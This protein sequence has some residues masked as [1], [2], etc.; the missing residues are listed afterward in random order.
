M[1]IVYPKCTN[2]A[3]NV[4]I[5]LIT[6]QHKTKSNLIRYL[7]HFSC[8]CYYISIKGTSHF[9]KGCSKSCHT[10]RPTV[11]HTSQP[12]KMCVCVCVFVQML[13]IIKEK[14]KNNFNLVPFP[15][16][17][18]CNNYAKWCV[19]VWVVVKLLK[20]VSILHVV[21]MR[22]CTCDNGT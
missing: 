15:C 6:K 8:I 10:C 19:F 14:K 3:K 4:S 5:S 12:W 21:R 7:F 9:P 13:I 18:P 2:N 22:W 17:T 20:V 1:C 11:W 16:L